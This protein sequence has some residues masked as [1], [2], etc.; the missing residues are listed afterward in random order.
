MASNTEQSIHWYLIYFKS[1][2]LFFF[3]LS[4]VGIREFIKEINFGGRGAY[5]P[6]QG[7]LGI[8]A[9]LE[10]TQR[11]QYSVQTLDPQRHLNYQSHYSKGKEFH[12]VLAPEMRK[13]FVQVFGTGEGF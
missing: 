9:M 13:D 12:I 5:F 8:E 2:H 7:F 11:G 10:T 1:Y 4:T 3:P 6:T